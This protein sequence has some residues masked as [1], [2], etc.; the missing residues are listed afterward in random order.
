MK[1]FT[2]SSYQLKFKKKKYSFIISES[3]PGNPNFIFV[4]KGSVITRPGHLIVDRGTIYFKG[5]KK[6]SRA[7]LVSDKMNT[8]EKLVADTVVLLLCSNIRT[9]EVLTRLQKAGEGMEAFSSVLK[10]GIIRYLK[11]TK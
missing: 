7:R 8:A 11:Y 9:Y 10:K 5:V 2:A 4:Y 1:S 3:S 6:G